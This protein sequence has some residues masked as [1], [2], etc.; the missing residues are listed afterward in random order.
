[1]AQLVTTSTNNP[2]TSEDLGS[3]ASFLRQFLLV[4]SNTSHRLLASSTAH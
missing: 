3:I 2:T 4:H 1:M